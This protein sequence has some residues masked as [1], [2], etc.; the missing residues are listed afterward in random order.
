LVQQKVVGVFGTALP[1]AVAPDGSQA[2]PSSTIVALSLSDLAVGKPGQ[3]SG[4]KN[5]PLGVTQLVS[6]YTRPDGA[7]ASK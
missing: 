1:V 4:T 3:D 5:T 2:P 7:A 6:R